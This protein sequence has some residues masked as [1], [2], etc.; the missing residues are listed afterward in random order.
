MKFKVQS[1]KFKDGRRKRADLARVLRTSNFELRAS[2]QRRGSVLV[3]VM[4]ILGILFVLGIAFLASMNFEADLIASETQRNRAES[5][6]TAVVDRL[7]STLRDGLM[8][9]A[10][11]PFGDPS[12]ALSPTAFA[13]MPGV[14]NSFSPIEP[15]RDDRGTAVLSDDKIRYRWF[16]D[17]EASQR[18]PFAGPTYPGSEI[19]TKIT[20]GTTPIPGEPV[21]FLDADG[22]GIA[23]SL[24]VD[25]RVL[26]FSDAQLA[27]LSA[28]LNP[29]TNPTGKVFVGI[30]VIPH[31]GLV[32]L[33]ASHPKLIENVLDVPPLYPP[34]TPPNPAEYGN[35][36][37]RPT[38]YQVA[39]SPLL[40]EPS[41]RRRGFLAPPAMPPS[42]LQGDRF[43]SKANGG[44]DMS[45]Q[46]WPPLP[47]ATMVNKLCDPSPF[48]DSGN[49]DDRRCF[50]YSPFAPDQVFNSS[51]PESPPAWAVRMEP[52]TADAADGTPDD[53]LMPE[54]DRRHLVT[55][56]SH[57]DL[58]V[59][60]GRVPNPAVPGGEEDIL[61]KM[62]QANQTPPPFGGECPVLLPFEYPDYPDT[63]P[64][65]CCPADLGCRLNA[66]KGRLQLSL[67]FLDERIAEAQGLND[68]K[69][70][71]EALDR[72]YRLI[73]DT[74]FL[75]V[76]NAAHVTTLEGTPCAS[77]ADCTYANAACGPVVP[78]RGRLCSVAVAPPALPATF[79]DCATKGC[80]IPGSVCHT[81]TDDPYYRRCTIQAPYWQDRPCTTN[82][83]CMGGVGGGEV[84][85]PA[86]GLC[87]DAW[88][89]QTHSQALISRTAAALTANLIDYADWE[90]MGGPRDSQSCAK[91][92]D[93]PGGTC[94]DRGIPTRVAL[95]SFDFTQGVC[96]KG[97]A[98]RVCN[99]N[100]DCGAGGLCAAPANAAGREFDFD[101]DPNFCNG[102]PAHLQQC[103]SNDN[104]PGGTCPV[105][106]IYVYGLERQPYI[107]EVA[108]AAESGA[109]NRVQAWGVELFNPYDTQLNASGEYLLREV[110]PGIVPPHDI[111]L[112]AV[113]QPNSGPSPKPF[114][115]FVTDPGN[116]GF[117]G[118]IGD[119][120]AG[121]VYGLAGPDALSF[122]NGSMLYL[123][124]RVRYTGDTMPTDIVVDQFAVNGPN[125]GKPVPGPVFQFSMERVV[126]KAVPWTAPVPDAEEIGGNHSIGDW[127]KFHVNP[128]LHPVEVNFAD[129]GS[130]SRRFENPTNANDPRNGSASFP[131]T[132]SLLMLMR[133]ANRSLQD[134]TPPGG[135]D[136]VTQLAFTTAL[137]GVTNTV[138][139]RFVALAI[140]EEEQIDN[141]RMPIFDIGVRS[142]TPTDPQFYAAHHV[143]PS[144]TQ[145]RA[146]GNLD[147][148][149]WGQLVFDYFTALP[150]S[151]PGPYV[152]VEP[153]PEVVVALPDSK[154]R[155]DLDGLRVHGR[156]NINAAPWKVLAGLPFVPMQRIPNAFRDR[157]ATRLGIAITAYADA[158][159]IGPELAQSMVAYREL[160][161]L[162]GTGNYGNGIA[163]DGVTTTPYVRGWNPT[164]PGPPP[165]PAPLMARR[166]TGFMSVGELAN[167]RHLGA[168]DPVHR[169]DSGVID[170]TQPNQANTRDFVDAVAALVALGDWVAVRSQVFTVYGVLRGQEDDGIKNSGLPTAAIDAARD[171][172]SRA[173]RFQETIDRLPT[174]LGA[175]VPSRIGDRSLT[176]YTDAHND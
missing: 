68:P 56:V 171:V 43:S 34:G 11:I 136:P 126:T 149:P 125:I 59:R 49:L 108:T 14:Q 153:G 111:P 109:P 131:T 27:A 133:H 148:L 33:N 42:W 32:N 150:L 143:S 19:D 61:A 147:T 134:Y 24:Q 123:I 26:G 129:L 106:P 87:V 112:N 23:D 122:Q 130:F 81:R 95:R 94:Q 100:A 135:G 4:T 50:R 141:G 142:A 101:S 78:N 28:R 2:R 120:A 154:P 91:D 170:P 17:L 57:D 118:L 96:T 13:E 18:R 40:E 77:D 38:K 69:L 166:G 114:T 72:V 173:L 128:Q 62:T 74:F 5:R 8:S 176:R 104:C 9:A 156:I 160:R 146:P 174:F 165:V 70:R 30:R 144:A 88:T 152:D 103:N 10:R 105:V 41:L 1:P 45:R 25:A 53:G 99:T 110:N 107:T 132:G 163:A 51:N 35:F 115:A 140:H 139:S 82:A 127:T 46:L 169:I 47:A 121:K 175:S 21:V 22:D 84:C 58:L 37:H 20:P 75:L 102:G 31:G 80:S 76:R 29:P 60:G 44:A 6:V 116:L 159:P 97:T 168:A 167:V 64:D 12:T 36:I 145:L 16:T 158:V 164:L 138:D 89:R 83:D 52:F 86:I 15:Y 151:N 98:G 172:D 79:D 119:S 85:D 155:V 73:H 63:I 65:D 48:K 39:Y 3:L 55:T 124:H 66:R 7:G 90:C 137:V 92:G 161:P 54:Y 113:L 162:P 93:C 117:L 67:P 157:I 71:Q